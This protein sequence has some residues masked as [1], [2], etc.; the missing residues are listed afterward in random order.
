MPNQ[1]P[2]A[3]KRVGDKVYVIGR[4]SRGRLT[5]FGAGEAQRQVQL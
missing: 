5:E 1:G 4:I 3:R 2:P